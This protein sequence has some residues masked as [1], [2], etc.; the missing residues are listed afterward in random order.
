MWFRILGLC[1][2]CGFRGY[3]LEVDCDTLIVMCYRFTC[4]LGL[5]GL[6]GGLLM[7]FYF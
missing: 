2:D 5:L 4:V 6:F 7:L 3:D 1:F